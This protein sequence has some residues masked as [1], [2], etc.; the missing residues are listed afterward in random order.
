MRSGIVERHRR[1][2][3]IVR[4]EV[5]TARIKIDVDL[6]GGPSR[7]FVAFFDGFVGFAIGLKSVLGL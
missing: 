7:I 3:G 2:I 5:P 1:V 6:L 4:I